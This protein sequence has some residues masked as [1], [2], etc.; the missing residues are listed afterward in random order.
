MLETQHLHMKEYKYATFNSTGKNSYTVK[1]NKSRNI[2]SSMALKGV[3]CLASILDQTHQ[4]R[5]A[6]ESGNCRTD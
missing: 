4:Y 2:L 3:F 6:E 1:L 5:L